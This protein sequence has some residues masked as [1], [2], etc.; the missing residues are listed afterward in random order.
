MIEE[1][2]EYWPS[3]A[4]QPSD[5]LAST[6]ENITSLVSASPAAPSH[7]VFVVHGHDEA[8]KQSVCRV[9]EKL[10]LNPIVLH[11]KP[12]RG[13]TIIEKF[14]DYSTVGFAVVL[15][16]PDDV[17]CE[18]RQAPAGLRPRPRQNVLLELGFFLGKLGRERVV[19]L[20]QQGAYFELPSD[21]SGVVFTEFDAAGQWRFEL[22]RELKAAD[23][24]VDANE[25]LA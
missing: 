24:S 1:V 21:Y 14:T 8:M 3:D 7:D 25:L 20:R 11:E 5:Q 2:E 12:N 22:V 13:R 4:K 18:R 15:L 16:S 17:G 6:M 23:Y 19:A 9:L 10:G